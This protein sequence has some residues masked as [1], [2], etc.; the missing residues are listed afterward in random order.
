MKETRPRLVVSNR[1]AGDS[2][3]P[4][5]PNPS[6]AARA[7]HMDRLLKRLRRLDADQLQFVEI[8]AAAI[9]RDE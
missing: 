3:S 8:M 9:V 5:P 2:E 7:E 6:S 1:R 4:A